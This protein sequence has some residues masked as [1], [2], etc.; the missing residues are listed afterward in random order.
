MK[1]SLLVACVLC[2]AACSGRQNPVT[3]SAPVPPACQTN[4]TAELTLAN[5]SPNNYTY[6]VL[7][8]NVKRGSIS[9]GQT[10]TVTLTAGI[11]H[12]VISQVTNLGTVACSSTPSFASCST[13]TLTCRF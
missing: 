2:V 10:L 9:V 1:G 3:P 11:T 12:T 8:D 5:A 4:S 6:D 13:Q 7:I